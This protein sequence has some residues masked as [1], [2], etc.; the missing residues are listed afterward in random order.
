M[1]NDLSNLYLQI[2]KGIF[3]GMFL[4]IKQMPFWAWIVMA[5]FILIV[6]FNKMMLHKRYVS[7]R[8]YEN[9]I[10]LFF[11]NLYYYLFERNKIIKS[12]ISEVDKM[13]GKDFEFYL[14]YLFEKMG[15]KATH[16]GHSASGHRGDFGGDVIVEK[17]NIKTVIQAKCYNGL[18]GIDA[19]REVMGAMKYY[20]CQKAMVVTNS[21]FTYEAIT[22]AQRADIELWGRNKLI[23][24]IVCLT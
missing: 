11:M 22:M 1:D 19:V 12:G 23:E 21:N 4:F 16:I 10:D 18:V 20:Q 17:D 13:S 7:S 14:K 8:K 5:V 6:I 2:F 9:Q 3:E 15:Y 24:K